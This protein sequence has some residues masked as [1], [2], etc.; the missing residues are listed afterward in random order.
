MLA[1]TFDVELSAI[2]IGPCL[3]ATVVLMKTGL[4]LLLAGSVF[5]GLAVGTTATDSWFLAEAG[6][7][8]LPLIYLAT[9][10]AVVLYTL[11]A[12]ALCHVT[13]MTVV[14]LATLGLVGAAAASVGVGLTFYPHLGH[15]VPLIFGTKLFVN[16]W[17]YVAFTQMWNFISGYIDIH[18]GKTE[19]PR[20]N[21]AAALGLMIGGGTI[22]FL[23]QRVPMAWFYFIW[24]GLCV[25]SFALTI[26][27]A[28]TMKPLQQ[29]LSSLDERGDKPRFF[30]RHLTSRYT[31]L[32]ATSAVLLIGVTVLCEWLCFRQFNVDAMDKAR[33]FLPVGA[34]VSAISEQARGI[35][36]QLFGVLGVCSGALVLVINLFLFSPLVKRIGV[37]NT[38]LIQPILYASAFT[39]LALAQGFASAVWA[40]LVFQGFFVA[41]DANTRNFL[42]NA[43]PKGNRVVVRNFIEGILEPWAAALAGAF[44][45]WGAMIPVGAQDAASS[46]LNKL[47][48]LPLNWLESWGGRSLDPAEISLIGLILSVVAF[49]MALVIRWL[50]PK[51]I[52]NNFLASTVHPSITGTRNAESAVAKSSPELHEGDGS[53]AAVL[54]KNLPVCPD[55]G[56]ANWTRILRLR[57]PVAVKSIFAAAH[58]LSAVGLLQGLQ[59]I[60]SAGAI[61]VPLS[62]GALESDSSSMTA[63]RLAV[64]A[65]AK[66]SR[67]QLEASS[68]RL[69]DRYFA[70]CR[71]YHDWINLATARNY[72]FANAVAKKLRNAEVELIVTLLHHTGRIPPPATVSAALASNEVDEKADVIEA[73]SIALNDP[74][75]LELMVGASTED[76]TSLTLEDLLATTGHLPNNRLP[77]A[78][79]A[80]LIIDDPESEPISLPLRIAILA[81]KQFGTSPLGRW[82]RTL[83]LA[84]SPLLRSASLDAIE[85]L[86]AE[87]EPPSASSDG[88]W[89]AAESGPHG[90]AGT[91]L[92]PNWLRGEPNDPESRPHDTEIVELSKD[93]LNRLAQLCP[94]VSLDWLAGSEEHDS[95]EELCA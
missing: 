83:A 89:I 88:L 49:V 2:D 78:L 82:Q 31:I 9:P 53:S 1:G 25:I 79:A 69:L 57:G 63:K 41:L 62:F 68:E 85:V 61:A 72:P 30:G 60:E 77:D 52:A 36:Q 21:G 75:R 92:N 11:L 91:C 90:P 73:L 43:S 44:L 23:A 71:T 7:D 14:L 16:S 28:A 37:G 6:A 15:A 94:N 17:L 70:R 55:P 81:E 86:A 22:A 58:R 95:K 48:N 42:F 3:P 93:W 38:I 76:S 27:I 4:F 87:I 35:M 47:F 64:E 74:E 46:L 19:F 12:T 13:S 5:A 34:T 32:I 10:I 56:D 20:L 39:A 45:F 50:Y 65:L 59:R 8:N 66:L 80:A 51:A 67:F 84:S 29:K 18:A 54:L 40:L 26:W 24:A 33:A